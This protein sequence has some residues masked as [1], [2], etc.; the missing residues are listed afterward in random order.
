MKT[1]RIEVTYKYTI[2]PTEQS[3]TCYRD[4]DITYHKKH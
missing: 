1:G 2:H 4:S 3:K